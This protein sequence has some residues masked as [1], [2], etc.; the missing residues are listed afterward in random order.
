MMGKRFNV[1]AAHKRM[2]PRTPENI[3]LDYALKRI[4]DGKQGKPATLE[5][6]PKQGKQDTRN[7]KELI[8]F[9]TGTEG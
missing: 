1:Q 3:A 5:I 8:Q 4:T 2:F 7:P 6:V 9:P